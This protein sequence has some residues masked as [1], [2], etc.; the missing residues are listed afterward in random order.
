MLPA[1][2]TWQAP[3]TLTSYCTDDMARQL[4]PPRC[5]TTSDSCDTSHCCFSEW[6]PQWQTTMPGKWVRSNACRFNTCLIIFVLIEHM[7]YPCRLP[8]MGFIPAQPSWNLYLYPYAG[9]WVLKGMGWGHPKMT[10]GLPMLI[11]SAEK[12]PSTGEFRS[13]P[14]WRQVTSQGGPRILTTTWGH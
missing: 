13:V 6:K 12:V 10:P 5:A 14:W 8:F 11:T 4:V 9:S 2:A 3:T 1:T 7:E